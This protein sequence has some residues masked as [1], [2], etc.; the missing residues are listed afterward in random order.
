MIRKG[1]SESLRNTSLA[2]C[3]ADGW[4]GDCGAHTNVHPTV[5]SSAPHAKRSLKG[6]LNKFL[7]TH[8]YLLY[9]DHNDMKQE[10]IIFMWFTFMSFYIK[11]FVGILRMC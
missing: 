5:Y 9:F 1:L 6:D 2:V 8:S 10:K 11:A 7:K 4:Q 3:P